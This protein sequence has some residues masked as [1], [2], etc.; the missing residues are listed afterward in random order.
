VKV[1]AMKNKDKKH[2][3]A[4][5]GVLSAL[6]SAYSRMPVFPYLDRATT[7]ILIVCIAGYAGLT[8]YIFFATP[9]LQIEARL[10]EGALGK[11]AELSLAPG[12][13]YVYYLE[14]PD[15]LQQIAYSV[16]S[17]SGCAGVMVIEAS[18]QGGQEVCIL[19]N[20]MSPGSDT[21]ANFGNQSILLFSP[22]M[23]SA[24]ENFS[25]EVDIVYRSN[26]MEVLM[27]TYFTSKGRKQM[28]SRDAYEIDISDS[29]GS[30]PSRFFVDAEKRVLLYADMGNV[31]V[32]MVS[33]PFALNWTN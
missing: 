30:A 28:A 16:D 9:P 1:V 25:W 21:N 19:K 27:P 5:D 32:T 26:G 12:E 22:W 4:A 10:S 24:S 15:G 13:K 7:L 33:A 8:A 29:T 2:S 23:L 14:S 11:N 20:G 31:T 18:G 6:A 17:Y 3:K